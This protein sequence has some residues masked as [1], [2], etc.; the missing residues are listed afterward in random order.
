[1]VDV[2][3]TAL[4]GGT[5]NLQELTFEPTADIVYVCFTDQPLLRSSTWLTITVIPRVPGDSARSTRELKFLGHP[6]LQQF[7]RWLWIDNRVSLQRD[8]IELFESLEADGELALALHDHRYSVLD[9]FSSV[10]RLRKDHPFPVLELKQFLTTNFPE[11]LEQ[12]PLAGTIILRR[13]VPAVDSLM[14]RWWELVLRYSARDQ[15]SINYAISTNPVNFKRL[16]IS[17]S[18]SQHHRYLNGSD[19]SRAKNSVDLRTYPTP[20]ALILG[21]AKGWW[22]LLV[23]NRLKSTIPK[24][25]VTRR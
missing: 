8:P 11:I 4:I 12:R 13:N 15:L 5:E 25:W 21:L 20:F 6:Y 23:W 7:D 19:V 1:M 16:P 2:V 9:E 24:L 3:Y 22:P 17:V 14:L 10:L 18:G